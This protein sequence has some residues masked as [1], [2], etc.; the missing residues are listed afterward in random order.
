MSVFEVK[1]PTS[2]ETLKTISTHPSH[3]TLKCEPSYFEKHSCSFLYRIRFPSLGYTYIGIK[4]LYHSG[5][6][7]KVD[8]QL[9]KVNDWRDYTSSSAAVNWLVK[10]G[11]RAT[12]EIIAFFPYH[13]TNQ[14]RYDTKRLDSPRKLIATRSEAYVIQGLLKS[15]REHILNERTL[16]SI[17]SE[18]QRRNI[19]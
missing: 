13:N 8:R 2:R 15:T 7:N 6:R 14:Y 16:K 18:M 1:V 12:Y 19:A 5:S 3:W 4:T 10:N 11:F 17:K 9:T